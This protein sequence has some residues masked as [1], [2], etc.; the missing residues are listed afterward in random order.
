MC[1]S[2]ESAQRQDN[3]SQMTPPPTEPRQIPVPDNFSFKWERPEDAHLPLRQD[4]QHA[5]SPITPLSG[6][7]TESHWGVG[8]AQGFATAKQPITMKIRRI[9]TYYYNAAVPT[10]PPEKMEE[11]GHAAEAW[12]K[13]AIP[14]FANRWE[15][16]W[17]P[18]IKKYHDKWNSFDLAGASTDQLLERLDWTLATYERLWAIHFEVAVTFLVAPSMFCDLY[19]DLFENAGSM[20]AYKLMQG[21]ENN[22]YRAGQDLWEL[23]RKAAASTNVK[24]VIKST[25][26]KNVQSALDAMPEGKKFLG[27][28]RA[29]L[30]KWGKRSDT[31]VELADP[32]W[33]EDPSIVIDNLKA[34]L[35]DG[36]TDPAIHWHE[37]VR[38]R[39]R[40]VEET[41][42][43][44]AGYPEPVRQQFEGMLAAGQHGQRI[45]EDHNW[46][47][48]QQGSYH[49][50]RVFL[51]FG[52]RLAKAGVIASAKDVFLLT[53]DEVKAAAAAAKPAGMKSIVATRQ[54]D[55]DKWAKVTPP[56][57]LGMDYGAPP[58]NPVTRAMGRMFGTPPAPPDPK[59]PELISGAPGAPGK[60]TG[61][62]R[63]IVKLAD[64]GRLGRGEILVTPTTSPPW[65]PLFVTAGGIVTDTGGG[66]SH[67]AIVAREYG[68]PA[69]VGSRMATAVIKD[70]QRIEVDGDAGT[71]RILGA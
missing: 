2:F 43:K 8:A 56:P 64:A 15:S 39:E 71:V 41:R 38:E 25:P 44:L 34:Y 47:I 19:S 48:D 51:E 58:D 35:E 59:H 22:S 62:A 54:A 42:K 7:L 36:A 29:Y 11:A 18:E 40:L 52:N 66:L 14:V 50:R 26:T 24:S 60:V 33:A 27:D 30:D 4:S 31:V 61:T 21:I 70:G 13:G 55:M 53:G 69:V 28:L 3:R 10:V 67:C 12:I 63:V 6:W 49:V 20:D 1:R 9:N 5:P 45:Q 23:S 46:W 65:T 57:A 68:I 32:T 16:E 37:I 17:L